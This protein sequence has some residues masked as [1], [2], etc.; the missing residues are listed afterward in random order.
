MNPTEQNELIEIIEKRII[1]KKFI[2]E[3]R[4]A[5]Y[6]SVLTDGVTSSNDEILSTHAVTVNMTRA[7]LEIFQNFYNGRNGRLTNQ[8]WKPSDT[9]KATS[10]NS[11]H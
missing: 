5:Q 11:F 9:D 1:Q 10:Y 4:D 7:Y 6:H 3:I 2:E 8:P